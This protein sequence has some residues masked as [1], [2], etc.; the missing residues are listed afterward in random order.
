MNTK[1]ASWFDIDTKSNR[2]MMKMTNANVWKMKLQNIT[3]ILM[4]IKNKEKKFK[5]NK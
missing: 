5:T 2:K 4:S 3:R 1:L